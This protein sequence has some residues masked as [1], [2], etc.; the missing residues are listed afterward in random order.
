[1]R[2]RWAIVLLLAL[3]SCRNAAPTAHATGS[4]APPPPAPTGLREVFPHVRVDPARR[5]VEFDA[6]VPH[7][8][9]VKEG[10]LVFL[11]VVACSRDTREHEAMVVTDARPSHVH[12]ALLLAGLEPGAP[13]GWTWKDG[14]LHTVEPKGPDVVVTFAYSRNGQPVEEPPTAWAK[15]VHSGKSWQDLA[16]PNDRFVFAGSVMRSDRPSMPYEADGAGT[17]IGLTTFGGETIAWTRLYSPEAEIEEPVWV[18]ARERTPPEGTP[19]VVR[20]RAK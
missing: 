16:T 11:E 8:A 13:G 17:L 7:Y 9:Y 19:V 14:T 5:L 20:L 4:K 10:G 15:N 12:A 1:M 3:A 18:V 2:S 6:M